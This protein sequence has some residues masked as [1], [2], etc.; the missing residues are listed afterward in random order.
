MALVHGQ[1]TAMQGTPEYVMQRILNI[2]P[3]CKGT[4]V[5]QIREH[6]KPECENF[7]KNGTGVGCMIGECFAKVDKYCPHCED[8]KLIFQDLEKHLETLAQLNKDRE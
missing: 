6:V 2:C 5:I 3:M 8:V 1:S 7:K 4:Q